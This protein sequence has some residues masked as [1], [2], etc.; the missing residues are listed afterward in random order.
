MSDLN[1]KLVLS[2]VDRITSPVDR[3]TKRL[4]QMT[5]PLTAG[6]S[7]LWKGFG[8]PKIGADLSNV[9]DKFGRVQG[10]AMSLLRTMGALT[11]GA[12]G[13]GWAFKRQFVDS[14]ANSE[15]FQLQLEGIEGSATKAKASLDWLKNFGKGKPFL[16]DD[17]IHAFT[18]LRDAGFADPRKH[19]FFEGLANTA[20][21]KRKSIG[22]AVD[23]VQGA[24]LGNFKGLKGL[25][26]GT[27]VSPDQQWLRFTYVDAAGRRIRKIT[28]NNT[29]AIQA[30]LAKIFYKRFPDAMT[31]A[32]KSWSGLMTQLSQAWSNFKDDVMDAGVFS[33][34]KQK[35]EWILETVN[36]M[37]K[38]GE[39]RRMAEEFAQKL[40][41]GFETAWR[42]LQNEFLPTM[43]TL[44]GDL[45]FGVD[46]LGGL[47]NTLALMAGI[48]MAPLAKDM[49]DLGKA[50]GDLT[51]DTVLSKLGKLAGTIGIIVVG[52]ESWS[53]I[54]TNDAL[55]KNLD[56]KNNPD[57]ART[58]SA[59][60]VEEQ[61]R[62]LRAFARKMGT[63][64]PLSMFG[65]AKP[66][67]GSAAAGLGP[68]GGARG[69]L[70]IDIRSDGAPVR[71][72]KLESAGWLDLNV[73]L[74][75]IPLGGH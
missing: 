59:G 55:W 42:F 41:S 73:D 8:F 50:I 11:F 66:F 15:E 75:P 65:P 5:K 1:V 43:K 71:V 58:G 2:A 68:A 26:I 22:E 52:M 18:D 20:A 37:A 49:L 70:Q 3:I 46:K 51:K 69:T 25:G 57:D 63:P 27:D 67:A 61:H 34:L 17:L 12:G 6:A 62:N 60:S 32:S 35:A 47:K 40:I 64:V 13:L 53:D 29:D 72:K 14:A 16:T 45:K 33:W 54:M 48:R 24:L 30:M 4:S 28:Q 44:W 31:K 74:G 39:L 23:A 21:A 10:S 9:A 19:G 38:S 56:P 7:A 36:R